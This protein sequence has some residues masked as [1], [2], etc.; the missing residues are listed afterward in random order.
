MTRGWPNLRP[1]AWGDAVGEDAGGEFAGGAP[2]DGTL[3]DQ[4]DAVGATQIEVFADDF[5]K[6]LAAMDGAVEDLG[7]GEF[8]LPDGEVRNAASLLIFVVQGKGEALEPALEEL[9]D[10][11]GPQFITGLLQALGIGALPEAVVQSLE[12]DALVLELA[13]GPL[14][15]PLRQILTG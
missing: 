12:G 13:F 2:G 11:R 4:L 5:L 15:W 14:I 9:L 10:V 3:E 1:G 6:E 8:Q 7:E